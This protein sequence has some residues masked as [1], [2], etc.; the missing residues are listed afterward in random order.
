MA[1]WKLLARLEHVA[2]GVNLIY[3]V[4]GENLPEEYRTREVLCD[5]C[6]KR[7]R[8][9]DTFV[10]RHKE[11]K[12]TK[13]VGSTCL[14]DF[15]GHM[16]PEHAVA[17]AAYYT[18]RDILG[19]YDDPDFDVY[20]AFM[21]GRAFIDSEHFLTLVA[22]FVEVDGW[23]SRSAAGFGGGSTCDSA[24]DLYFPYRGKDPKILRRRRELK[25]QL[26]PDHKSTA[27]QALKWMAEEMATKSDYQ[28]NLHAAAKLGE[29][30]PKNCGI[31]ASGI[32]AYHK[33]LEL[34]LKRK[35][36]REAEAK[37]SNE[38]VAEQGERKRFDNLTLVRTRWIEGDWGSTTLFSFEDEKGN[39]IVW[40]S[41]HSRL[42]VDDLVKKCKA[43]DHFV[44]DCYTHLHIG[45]KVSLTG[46]V[47]KRDDYKGRKQTVLTRCRLHSYEL[48]EGK[49]SC[50]GKADGD[51]VCYDC[52]KIKPNVVL[53]TCPNCNGSG[54]DAGNSCELCDGSGEAEYNAATEFVSERGAVA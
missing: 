41:S 2:E 43:E 38:W 22:L 34:E 3:S 52:G 8:R 9:K 42:K 16:S 14:K 1:G 23:V 39:V 19:N 46:R 10:V 47:K 25:A 5:H 54:A 17:L 4:P 28:W 50:G 18:E 33:H 53:V 12:V 29:T 40:F 27:R 15:L 11:T 30:T 31:L 24:L 21:K 37:K 35:F 20:G 49:C 13:Q 6:E 51:G 48:P 32:V 44:C 26:T 36:E 7:R 45:G